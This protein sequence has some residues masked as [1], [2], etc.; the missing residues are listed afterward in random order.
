MLG[1]KMEG[2]KKPIR[3]DR[4]VTAAVEGGF[5]Q[6]AIESHEEEINNLK[7]LIT[8]LLEKLAKNF[9]TPVEIM[10]VIGQADCEIV[11][12]N[13]HSADTHKYKEV[14]IHEQD[15]LFSFVRT[16]E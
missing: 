5:D 7:D 6:G 14:N 9:L 3:L 1:I 10:K 4:L 15:S 2:T 12:E 8:R 16:E 11:F 13:Q